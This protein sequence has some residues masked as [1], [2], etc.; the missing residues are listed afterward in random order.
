MTRPVSR[1]LLL[2]AL[3]ALLPACSGS[4]APFG[5]TGPNGSQGAALPATPPSG[6][7]AAIPSPGNPTDFG[8]RY[9]PSI[10]PTFGS[11]GRF[12]GYN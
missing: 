3:A 5:L 8:V 2:T 12:Y 1:V 6:D 9:S 11:D 7:D 4:P 10:E